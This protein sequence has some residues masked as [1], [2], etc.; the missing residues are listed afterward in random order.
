MNHSTR[1]RGMLHT[2]AEGNGDVLSLQVHASSQA[3]GM[4]STRGGVLFQFVWPCVQAS[5]YRKTEQARNRKL[6]FWQNPI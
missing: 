2:A 5:V 1:H 3:G 4:A 6:M